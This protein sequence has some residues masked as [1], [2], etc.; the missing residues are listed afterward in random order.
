M[1]VPG[2]CGPTYESQSVTA[3]VQTCRN[4]YPER[5]EVGEDV[6]WML[7]PTPGLSS[8][9]A[10]SH[11][12]IRATFSQDGRSFKVGG[13]RFYEVFA[14]GTST[15]RGTVAMGT[16]LASICSNGTAG[17]QLLIVSGGYG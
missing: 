1:R 9:V 6:E 13:D 2:F 15:E 12:P 17:G 5:I 4:W 10:S 16:S 8:L 3:A 11:G 7:Q 14:N